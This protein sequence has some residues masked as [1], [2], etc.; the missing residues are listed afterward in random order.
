MREP[1]EKKTQVI[2]FRTDERT[3]ELLEQAADYNRRTI[4]QLVELICL[5]WLVDPNPNE[6]VVKA[7]D[8]Y[9]RIEEVKAEAK[10]A[11][12]LKID[13][14]ESTDGDEIRKVLYF[15]SLESGG[16]GICEDFDPVSEMTPAEIKEI[17]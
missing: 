17:P 4:G 3:K 10:H 12:E 8:F 16:L 5:N 6:I 14:E 1:K 2:S 15:G 13:V 7:K 9:E 11:I